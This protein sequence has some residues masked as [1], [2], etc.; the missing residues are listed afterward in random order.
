MVVKSGQ[1]KNDECDITGI[2]TNVEAVTNLLLDK[3]NDCS[4]N[5]LYDLLYCDIHL[6]IILE[7]PR[8]D[9]M[10]IGVLC[11]TNIL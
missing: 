8:I 6:T 9:Y 1:I 10:G 11:T 7:P 5:I 2:V 3:S 4:F